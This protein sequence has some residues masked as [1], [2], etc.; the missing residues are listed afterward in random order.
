MRKLY[1]TTLSLNGSKRLRFLSI[2]LVLLFVFYAL[3]VFA[4]VP[5]EVVKT[6]V[7]AEGVSNFNAIDSVAVDGR[8]YSASAVGEKFGYPPPKGEYDQRVK[9][10]I[11]AVRYKFE[12]WNVGKMG[13]EKGF[14]FKS[15][16][17]KAK[18]TRTYVLGQAYK[19]VVSKEGANGLNFVEKKDVRMPYVDTTFVSNLEFSGGPYG[20]FYYVD[21]K[22]VKFPIAHIVGGKMISFDNIPEGM[23]PNDTKF[24]MGLG[25]AKEVHPI[26]K[27][28]SAFEKWMEILNQGDDSGCSEPDNYK[29]DVG[30]RFS[31]YDGE[32]S[33][34]PCNDEDGWDTAEI[35]MVLHRDD[36]IKTGDD[37]TCVLSLS[38]M[39]HFVMKPDSEVI[40]AAPSN[41]ENKIKLIWGKIKTNFKRMMKDGTMDVDMS[42]AVA[43]I[44]GTILVTEETGTQSTLKVIRGHVNFTSK[45]TGKSVMVGPGEMVVATRKGLG[46]KQNFNVAEENSSWKAVESGNYTQYLSSKNKSQGLS[47][48]FIL[49]MLIF[50]LIGVGVVF[51]F[52]RGRSDKRGMSKRHSRK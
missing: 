39:T 48:L 37:S 11:E 52:K 3:P 47:F 7:T 41:N 36:H 9:I 10:P 18:L 19:N 15:S 8:L 40:L 20:T 50:T 24:L 21:K 35:D 31:D 13:G 25:Y 27:D 17:G 4:D 14:I 6:Y 45:V 22:G 43:G 42:Q 16:Y 33:V 51:Y 49:L 26:I 46:K 28:S 23:E 30:I 29:R 5:F 32:V 34:R 44:K 1:E 12:F 2:F 38:D